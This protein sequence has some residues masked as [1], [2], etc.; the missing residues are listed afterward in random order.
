MSIFK[1]EIEE[2]KSNDMFRHIYDIEKKEGKYIFLDGKKYVNLSSNDYLGLSTNKFLVDEFISSCCSSSDF[3]FSSAS[4]RL[5]SGNSEV[6]KNL[7]QQLAKMFS[8]EAALLFN[9]GYQCNLGVVSAFAQKQDV[10]FCD[11]LN[12][13]SII[14]GIKLSGANFYRYKHLNYEHLEE[15]LK[16]YRADYKRA[17]IISESV[18]SM[19]GDIADIK[20]LVEL[21]E[22]YNA[23]LMID[24]AH[25]FGIFGNNICGVSEETGVLR[26]VD[27]ITATFGKSIASMGAFV[28][29][30]KNMID[31]F[32]NKSRSFIFS[33]ALPP[34]NILW[35]S[36]LLSKKFNLLLEKKEKVRTLI[37][38]T[39][40]YI[41]GKGIDCISQSQ[42]IPIV[43]GDNR[44]AL[45]LALFLQEHGFFVLP[46][47]PPSVAPKS[48]RI[49]LSLNAGVSVDDIREIVDLVSGELK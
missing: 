2:L 16:K 39:L 44:K 26:N 38:I 40:D 10:I 4:A 21:K 35:T 22:K 25:A 13:A 47:R 3:L 31:Y 9:T 28:V 23:V 37:K 1:K 46:I 7:E 33:T 20:K 42:I 36:W 30:N 19:D 18:F 5:L 43:T 14:D 41:K 11:K 15:L 12:H 49:R 45:E 48:S 34:V 8:K 24:E 6:Y 29:S 27:I 17:L 32:I